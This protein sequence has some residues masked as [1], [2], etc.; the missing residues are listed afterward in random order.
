MHLKGF[1]FDLDGTLIDSINLL[2]RL[3]H[4]YFKLF[5]I[6]TERV[7]RVWYNLAQLSERAG[8]GFA[9]RLVYAINCLEVNKLLAVPMLFILAINYYIDLLKCRPFDVSPLKQKGFKLAIVTNSYKT[10][11]K[12]FSISR[13]FDVIVCRGDVKNLKPDAE[14]FHKAA[15]L[16][17]L[18]PNE[19]GVVDDQVINLKSARKEGFITIGVL[20]GVEDMS[21]MQKYADMV[22][23]DVRELIYF[24]AG[25]KS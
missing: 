25:R 23:K 4:K 19:I 22:F 9:P 24:F 21:K 18:E 7:H 12:H 15:R 2:K 17:S 10:I 6:S 13:E 1:I 11:T 20:S 5:G 8:K 14:P 16:M 3:L